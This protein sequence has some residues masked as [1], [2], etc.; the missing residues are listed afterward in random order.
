[1]NVLQDY[2]CFDGDTVVGKVDFADAIDFGKVEQY[3]A[4]SYRCAAQTGIAALWGNGDTVFKTKPHDFL[5]IFYGMRLQDDVRFGNKA[6]AL[7]V[8]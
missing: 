2:A 4:G 5:Y 7:V 1:M 8:Q 3:A 6:A